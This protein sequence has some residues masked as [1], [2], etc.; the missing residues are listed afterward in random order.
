MRK[1]LFLDRDGVINK[2]YGYVHRSEQCDFVEGIR[3]L[4]IAA[5]SKRYFIVVVTNQS[6]IGRGYYSETQ[7]HQFMAWM[8]EQLDRMLDAIYFSPFHASCGIGVYKKESNCRKPNPGMLWQ[9][10]KEHAIDSQQSILVG[11]SEKDILAAKRGN[12]KKAF[13]LTQQANPPL[14]WEKTQV[15]SSL[16]DVIPYL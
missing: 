2:D 1:A 16:S 14:P 11:D 7:F 13:Y 8:N 4:L 3:E 10:M 6:G 15:I 5:K 9:A 12:L